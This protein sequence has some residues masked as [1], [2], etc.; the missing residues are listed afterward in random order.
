MKFTL[1]LEDGQ[2]VARNEAGEELGHAAEPWR[3]M[4]PIHLAARE[5][6]SRRRAEFAEGDGSD[7]RVEWRSA[8]AI[9]F[10]GVETSDGRLIE[11]GAS[12]WRSLPMPL[13][14]QTQTAPGHFEAELA[15]TIETIER[16]GENIAATGFFDRSEAGE[17][18]AQVL[19]DHPKYGVSIDVG[20]AEGE[21]ECVSE[22]EEGFCEEIRVVFSM[23]EIMG[24]TGTPWP[25]FADA[26]IELS[27]GAPS[28]SETEEDTGGEDE[29]ETET[30]DDADAAVRRP[31]PVPLIAAA[32]PTSP[33]AE[34]FENPELTELTPMT[35]TDE[36]RI[37]GHAFPWNECH[38]GSA[39]GVFDE[40]VIAPHSAH[41][42]AYFRTG[43]VRPDDCDCDPIPT[44][45]LTMATNHASTRLAHAAAVDYYSN[46]GL[47]AA[48]LVLGED[49]FGGWF[50]GA[51]RP[52]LTEE[53]LRALRASAP[54]G[55]WRR[56]GGSL[57]LIGILAVNTPGFPVSR[58]KARVASGG[59]Q[60]LV[61]AGAMTM[62]RGRTDPRD[63]EISSLRAEVRRLSSLVE[64]LRPQAAAALRERIA[65]SA[66]S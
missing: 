47:A 19:A 18:F 27:S 48:D 46:T 35:I 8:P 29:T 36:G 44:G 2:W 41:D 57:E 54:S 37:F 11:E 1:N 33:P 55:D 61:A 22:D 52:T 45:V 26:A 20:D 64:P 17:R 66:S 51:L 5:E 60:A 63:A 42:Y 56:A 50:S 38:V 65:A 58:T 3:A 23:I 28:E 49:E 16:S 12:S 39:Q 6:L 14:L 4:A 13:M 9:A 62:A 32:I 43:E 7:E 21:V 15:G 25:A 10:E 30:E 34:W 40:C 24:A 31:S 53:D 59:V